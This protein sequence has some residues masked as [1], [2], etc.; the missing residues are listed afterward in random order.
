MV[1]TARHAASEELEKIR[2]A[3]SGNS[4]GYKATY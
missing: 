2:M 1:C 3:F 4:I